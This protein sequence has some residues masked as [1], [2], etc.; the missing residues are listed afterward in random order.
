MLFSPLFSLHYFIQ[1][2]SPNGTSLAI[3][4]NDKLT[5]RYDEDNFETIRGTYESNQ[6]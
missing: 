4:Q 1:A 2:L 5:L 6:T 3:L